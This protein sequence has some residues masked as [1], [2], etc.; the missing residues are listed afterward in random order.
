MSDMYLDTRLASDLADIKTLTM[1]LRTAALGSVKGGTKN[2]DI[3]WG[4]YLALIDDKLMSKEGLHYGILIWTKMPK[5]NNSDEV[6][7]CDTIKYKAQF[8][9]LV[10]LDNISKNSWLW[11][12]YNG[13]HTF[14]IIGEAN[15]YVMKNERSYSRELVIKQAEEIYGTIGWYN[16]S[17]SIKTREAKW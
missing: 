13:K 5:D 17:K 1:D 3:E 6:E 9:E 7:Y 10:H 14:N 15:D 4:R 16:P 12:V 11:D 2:K 8:K